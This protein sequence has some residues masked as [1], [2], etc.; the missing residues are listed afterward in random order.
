MSSHKRLLVI[1]V[2]FPPVP[3]PLA[4]NQQGFINRK[5]HKQAS[6]IK[7]DQY[8]VNVWII[9]TLYEMYG[10]L[11]K[12]LCFARHWKKDSG[13]LSDSNNGIAVHVIKTQHNVLWT[14]ARVLTKEPYPMKRKVKEGLIVGRTKK[15]MVNGYQLDSI[16][17]GKTIPQSLHLKPNDPPPQG[18]W[19]TM[20]TLNSIIYTC[21]V[22]VQYADLGMLI[23]H[24]CVLIV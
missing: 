20:T 18:K 21:N 5:F 12:G 3:H 8:V 13:K 19:L 17:C 2:F 9:Y 10:V 14:E 22:N 4:H 15:N 11:D 7:A 16:L 6:Y 1:R 24:L 23:S